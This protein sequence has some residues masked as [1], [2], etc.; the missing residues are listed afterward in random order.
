MIG[1][2]LNGCGTFGMLPSFLLSIVFYNDN[3]FWGKVKKRGKRFALILQLRENATKSDTAGPPSSSSCPLGI[4]TAVYHILLSGLGDL[5]NQRPSNWRAPTIFY[6][7][8]LYVKG[9]VTSLNY[10][11]RN[12]FWF[13]LDVIA[14]TDQNAVPPAFWTWWRSLDWFLLVLFVTIGLADLSDE[15]SENIKPNWAQR[16]ISLSVQNISF[17][18]KY[19]KPE[20]QHRNYT[21]IVTRII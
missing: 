20:S 10:L 2:A 21:P 9:T 4:T 19:P 17:R 13:E 1:F 18:C 7:Y 12:Q 11:N 16:K 6:L 8:I 15:T 14:G 3:I 5:L